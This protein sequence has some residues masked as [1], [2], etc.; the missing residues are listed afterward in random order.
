MK[1]LAFVD[2][3]GDRKFLNEVIKKSKK[4]DIVVCGGDIT[5]FGK[6]LDKIL[7]KLSKIDKIILMIQ[8]NHEEGE[9]LEKK[10][11]KY[12][13]IRYLHQKSFRMGKKVFFG[14]GEG[15]FARED[16]RFERGVKEFKKTLKKDDEVILI[17]HGNPYKTKFDLLYDDTH[18][19]NKSFN[20]AIKWLKPVL[21]ICGHLHENTYVKD[22]IGSTLV[23]NPGPDGTML[24]V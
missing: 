10:C 21:Y 4:A 6:D 7:K 20:R 23:I 15:N 13:N 11:R 2:S 12:K 14:Y 5:W 17:T 3:H 1:I 19:G 24:K 18:V 16:K 22:V 9:G 8:G